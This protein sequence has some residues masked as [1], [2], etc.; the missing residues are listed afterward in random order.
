MNLRLKQ[1]WIYFVKS[2]DTGL[3]KIGYTRDL[4]RRLSSL[5]L[6]SVAGMTLITTTKSA[7]GPADE[8]YLHRYLNRFR[9]YGEWFRITERQAFAAR[10][11][12]YAHKWPHTPVNTQRRY[13]YIHGYLVKEQM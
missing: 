7:Y 3:I 5:R 2:N 9:A 11:H 8:N 10:R 12:L 6:R 4:G 13:V 1:D